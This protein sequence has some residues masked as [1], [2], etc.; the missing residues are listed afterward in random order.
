MGL[1]WR[2][3]QYFT[4][5]LLLT[6]YDINIS[7]SLPFVKRHTGFYQEIFFATTAKLKNGNPTADKLSD[8]RFIF[9]SK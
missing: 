9:S 5:R 6:T 2:F 7:Y 8:S 4:H 3:L 1:G